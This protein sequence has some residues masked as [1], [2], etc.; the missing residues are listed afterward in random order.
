MLYLFS[1]LA[2][3][4]ALFPAFMSLIESMHR[5]KEQNKALLHTAFTVYGRRTTDGG[6]YQADLWCTD[7]LI[8][9]RK[10]KCNLCLEDLK[11][12][13]ISKLHARLWL[14]DGY[15][16][17]A[18]APNGWIPGRITYPDV[19]VNSYLVPKEG[20]ILYPGDLIRLGNS[21]FYLK[22]TKE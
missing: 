10:R 6:E 8:G 2:G 5:R 20:M 3:L 1:I 9:R 22:D 19:Y 11:D 17:I 7:N 18:P 12:K 13:N 4:L 14:Q 16:C 15:F 21:E